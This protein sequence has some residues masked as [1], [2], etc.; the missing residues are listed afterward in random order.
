MNKY[1]LFIVYFFVVVFSYTCKTSPSSSLEDGLFVGDTTKFGDSIFVVL[2]KLEYDSLVYKKVKINLEII[3]NCSIDVILDSSYYNT[4]IEI[5]NLDSRI[6]VY[7]FPETYDNIN[8]KIIL[9]KNEKRVVSFIWD[10]RYAASGFVEY[11]EY[12]VDAIICGFR[13]S[14]LYLDY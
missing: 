13:P 1:F 10:Y 3:N 5:S 14:A 7:T 9:E 12:K 4:N 8:T 2:Q 11:G 6:V